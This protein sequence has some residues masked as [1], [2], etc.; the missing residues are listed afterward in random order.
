M[1][2][3]ADRF[4]GVFTALITPFKDGAVDFPAYDALVA[5]QLEAGV[6]GLVPVGTTGE[7]ATLSEEEAEALIARTVKLAEGRALILAGA[8]ANDTHKAIEKAKRAETA[9]ADALL[10]V[11]PY[12]NKPSQAG[13]VAHYAAVAEST[14]LP[15]VLYSVPG[16][17]GVEIAPETCAALMERCGNI[18]AIKEAGGDAARVTKLR[19][20]C[21]DRLIVHSGDDA[22]TLPFLSLGAVGVTSVVSNVAPR[23][24][25][26]MV[27]AWHTG[28]IAGALKLHEMIA[29]L[30]DSMFIESNPG[31][32]K[33]ALAL[34]NLAGPEMRLPMV[35][36]S[37]QTRQRLTGILTRFGEASAQFREMR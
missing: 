19:A 29:E 14:S 8:G 32:V 4:K 35:P 12:Y 26:A 28:D 37:D 30:T 9:G 27:N 34:S 23:E 3:L 15:I 18:V 21:G 6:A 7:A 13:L 25:V 20:A 5:R 17:C 31:P 16:R 2:T 36:V 1:N 10:V 22:L 33:A 24:M 11:T